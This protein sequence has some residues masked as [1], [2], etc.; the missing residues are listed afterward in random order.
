MLQNSNFMV[1]F[2]NWAS[3]L[4][5]AEFL[6]SLENWRIWFQYFSRSGKVGKKKTSV[7]NQVCISR[8][9]FNVYIF[10]SPCSF[11]FCLSILSPLY[12]FHFFSPSFLPFLFAVC[13]SILT[14]SNSSLFPQFPPFFCVVIPSFLSL[15]LKPLLPSLFCFNIF[16]LTPFIPSFIHS[17]SFLPC[18]PLSLLHFVCPSSIFIFEFFHSSFSSLLVPFF[19]FF[20][21]F[22]VPSSLSFLS[23]LVFLSLFFLMSFLNFFFV[24]FRL[25]TS[26][27]SHSFFFLPV[28]LVL[29]LL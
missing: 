12:F 28:F 22:S 21:P 2:S 6:K 9:Y 5:N 18:L 7:K 10:F 13:S 16:I 25:F 17:F 23:F 26:H 24:S 3:L 20:V 14:S 4:V 8:S 11:F 1:S 29:F 19:S 27:S 15:F